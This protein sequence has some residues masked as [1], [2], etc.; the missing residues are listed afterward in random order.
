MKVG[1][2]GAGGVG[3]TLGR[4]LAKAGH[5]VVYGVRAPGADK[6]EGLL[7]HATVKSVRDA[8]AATSA[9]ILATPWSAAE[10]AVTE[11]GDFE[12][13]PLLDA[14]NPIGP[15]FVL[16]HGLTSSGAE[17]VSRWAKNARVVKAFNSTGLENMANPS[18][19]EARAAMFV[20]GD[21]DHACAIACDL[22]SCLG[23]EAI[24]VGTLSKARV[25]EPV[26]M[27]W[28]QLAL[29]KGNGRNIA[30]G[31]LRRHT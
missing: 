22:A 5:E 10:P 3:A 26:A 1:I 25:L 28:I 2:L 4:A 21:D 31:V 11:A 12:N 14:T 9:V 23:F 30:F 13:K 17:Q 16:T 27:L 7:G 29:E 6:H 20:C 8:V 15:G 24:R 19:G 18:Y